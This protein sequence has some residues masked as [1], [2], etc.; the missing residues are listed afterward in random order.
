MD[1]THYDFTITITLF[2]DKLK[3]HF[4][5][6]GQVYDEVFLQTVSNYFLKIAEQITL[7]PNIKL[8]DIEIFS[9]QEKAEIAA[10]KEVLDQISKSRMVAEFDF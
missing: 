5:Y 7:N 1:Y 4:I 6:N 3:C 8:G 10:K 9:A 2:G